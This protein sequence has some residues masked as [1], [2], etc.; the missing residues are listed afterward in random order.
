MPFDEDHLSGLPPAS[1]GG[2]ATT[3]PQLSTTG[4]AEFA[5]FQSS[6]KPIGIVLISTG[7]GT[8]LRH[9]G[10]VSIWSCPFLKHEKVV[11]HFG[12]CKWCSYPCQSS[13]C[14]ETAAE[15]SGSHFVEGHRGLAPV[16]TRAPTACAVDAD[17]SL[18]SDKGKSSHGEGIV[19]WLSKVVDLMAF[20]RDRRV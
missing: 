9:R 20:H 8:T 10:R 11:P 13:L 2:L 16:S 6:N 18:A 14:F 4:H 19:S 5:I 1:V 15:A 17:P 7:L 3:C 12:V